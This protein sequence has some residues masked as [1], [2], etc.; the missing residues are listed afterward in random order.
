MK[1]FT[2]IIAF[3]IATL[4]TVTSTAHAGSVTV[5]VS[6]SPITIQQGNQG[7]LTVTFTVSG[8]TNPK[9]TPAISYCGTITLKAD[10]TFDCTGTL[11]ALNAGQNYT[12][13]GNATTFTREIT[14]VVPS[15]VPCGVTYNG[16]LG[17]ASSAGTGLDFGNNVL[18]IAIPFAVNVTCPPALT[19]EGCG[20]GYWKTHPAAWPA[21][22][23]DS[24]LADV[25]SLPGDFESLSGDSLSAAL[26]YDGGKT[27]LDKGKLLLMQAVASV[28]NANVLG[29]AFAY[30]D[31]QVKSM[32][33]TA[34]G[35]NDADTILQTKDLFEQANLAFC[36]LN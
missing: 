1:Q 26:S 32:V 8:S 14:I 35:S 5:A 27:V 12:V 10:G 30:T 31:A 36:P 6:G 2:S 20:H 3:A 22:Y 23:A 28:L 21:S 11:L 19:A 24:T 16:S 9:A 29:S 25:F 7:T 13:R 17:F 4:F 33:T 34:L 18:Q 15:N